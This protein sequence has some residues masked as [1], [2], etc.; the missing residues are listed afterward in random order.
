MSFPSLDFQLCFNE[1]ESTMS[2]SEL[3]SGLICANS[4]L[5]IPISPS[6]P[7][8]A[9]HLHCVAPGVAIPLSCL[10]TCIPLPGKLTRRLAKET[11]KPWSFKVK[12]ILY[13]KTCSLGGDFLSK[14]LVFSKLVSV[15]IKWK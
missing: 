4:A 2:C 10:C 3:L 1:V 11:E 9:I 12:G 15:C 6:I 14:P 13:W 8:H 7:Q 5:A